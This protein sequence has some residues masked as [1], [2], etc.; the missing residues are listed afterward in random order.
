MWLKPEEG[1]TPTPE[2]S[3]RRGRCPAKVGETQTAPP[4]LSVLVL[5]EVN[6]IVGFSEKT[7]TPSP[8]TNYFSSKICL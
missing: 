8:Q 4:V 1:S 5:A 3:V 2:E 7:I 6:N